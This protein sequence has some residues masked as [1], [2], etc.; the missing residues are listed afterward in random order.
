MRILRTTDHMVELCDELS[1]YRTHCYLSSNSGFALQPRPGCRSCRGVA[2]PRRTA[3]EA[4]QLAGVVVFG[5]RGK[6]AVHRDDCGG[7]MVS[8]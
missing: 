5:P 4:S 8:R 3:A 7:Q 1:R 2:G 6:L